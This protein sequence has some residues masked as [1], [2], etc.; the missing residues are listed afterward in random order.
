MTDVNTLVGDTPSGGVLL[1][2]L[3][4]GSIFRRPRVRLEEDVFL[5]GECVPAGFVSNGADIPFPLNAVL[6]PF[7]PWAKAAFLHDA[8]LK[9]GRPRRYCAKKF[10]VGLIE[11]GLPTWLHG[12]FYFVVRAW[13]LI[14]GR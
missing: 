6:S 8:L 9:R 7:G 4:Q 5:A 10:K 11:L 1:T 13:D 14:R 3:D 12:P 2:L